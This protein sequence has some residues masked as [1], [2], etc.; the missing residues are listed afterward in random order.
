MASCPI[1]FILGTLLCCSFSR[2]AAA[3]STPVLFPSFA[4]PNAETFHLDAKCVLLTK[5]LCD[6]LPQDQVGTSTAAQD[7][8]QPGKFHRGFN[9]FLRDQVA[10]FHRPFERSSFVWTRL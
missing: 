9:R 6:G 4:Q 5:A 1:A 2:K 10:L 3:Q 8:G 7:P